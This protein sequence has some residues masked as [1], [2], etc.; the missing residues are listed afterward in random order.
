MAHHQAVDEDVDVVA[1]LLVDVVQALTA[2]Q[3]VELPVTLQPTGVEVCLEL[4]ALS[5][6]GD[7]VEVLP[8]ARERRA[9]R[10]RALEGDADST[11]RSQ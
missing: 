3:R 1:V 5:R 8:G 2:V 4:L 7:E 9:H 6:D 11:E 10:G